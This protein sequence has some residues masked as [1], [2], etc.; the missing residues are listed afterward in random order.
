MYVAHVGGR[1]GASGRLVL[2]RG[3]GRALLV[4]GG[5]GDGGLHHELDLVEA[6]VQ[7][8]GVHSRELGQPRQVPVEP[9]PA[10]RRRH[11]ARRQR[12]RG[13]QREPVI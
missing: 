8:V 13:V 1:G 6:G 10:Q 4:W 12:A 7:A 9:Q 11:A 5:G 3:P 2:G